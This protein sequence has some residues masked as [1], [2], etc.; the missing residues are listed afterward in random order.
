MAKDRDKESNQ[1]HSNLPVFPA[2]ASI[3]IHPF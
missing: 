3:I 1:A 2:L